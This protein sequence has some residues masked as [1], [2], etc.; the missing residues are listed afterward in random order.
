VIFPP[1]DLD[2]FNKYAAVT[3]RKGLI[4]A[5]RQVPYKRFDLAIAAAIKMNMPL[6]VIGDGPMHAKLVE[7][8]KGHI[9]INFLLNPTDKE[10]P[11]LFSKA[12]LFLF[13]GVEDFG[14]TPV[15]A[16]AA[17]TPVVAYAEGGSLDY[18]TDTTG[19]LFYEQTVANLAEAIETALLSKWNHKKIS[20]EVKRF[21]KESFKKQLSSVVKQYT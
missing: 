7:Q 2:R 17:G 6:T 14:I 10:M 5:G 15:E 13:P 11:K 12:E 20:K 4:I 18:V 8:A 19:V 3:K 1:V 9:N 21:N 16:M